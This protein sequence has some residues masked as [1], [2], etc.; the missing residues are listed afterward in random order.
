M[1]GK[2]LRRWPNIEPTLK[3][4]TMFE[5]NS[6]CPANTSICIKFVQRRPNVF[7]PTLYKV[8]QMFCF[9]RASVQAWGQTCYMNLLWFVNLLLM[10]LRVWNA[11]LVLLWNM[12]LAYP[13]APLHS[14]GMS[15]SREFCQLT[16]P[17]KLRLLFVVVDQLNLTTLKYYIIIKTKGIF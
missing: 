1:L 10:R 9:H 16:I 17:L 4:C 11:Y 14:E 12:A 15:L 2:R 3:K 13:R 6:S 7:G 5:R 8:I